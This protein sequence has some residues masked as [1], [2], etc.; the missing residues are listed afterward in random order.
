M[1]LPKQSSFPKGTEF[2]IYE[3]DVPISKEVNDDGKTV[4]YFNWFGGFKRAFPIE[5]LKIDNNWPAE[6]Y[7]EWVN[8]ISESI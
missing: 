6:S 3:W 7:E 8:L 2:Y 5:S 1:A 4:S